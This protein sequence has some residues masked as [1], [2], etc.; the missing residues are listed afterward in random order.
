M[1]TRL[2]IALACV[3]LIGGAVAWKM[4]A[5]RTAVR[6]AIPP[7]VTPARVAS[8]VDQQ[9][10]KAE[11]SISVER[12]AAAVFR[13]AFWR[14]PGAG[15]R[16]LHGERRDWSD[17]SAAVQKWAWFVA[18][19]PSPELRRWLLEENPFDLVRAAPDGAAVPLEQPP[20]WFPAPGALAAMTQ[21]RNRGGRL[22]VFLD[23]KTG[24]IFATDAGAGFAAAI[25]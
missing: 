5:D 19:A 23:D 21:Y 12:D 16:V 7:S 13:R 20:S 24:R 9:K 18:V 1:K 17:A 2:V 22:V 3:A 10:S 6:P 15:D 8:P 25:R 4:E 14:R 11:G